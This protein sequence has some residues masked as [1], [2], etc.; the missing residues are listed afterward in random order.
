MFQRTQGVQHVMRCRHGQFGLKIK[1]GQFITI[2]TLKLAIKSF[3][4]APYSKN[5]LI[6]AP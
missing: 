1:N 3:P 5:P 2:K 6:L 4:L